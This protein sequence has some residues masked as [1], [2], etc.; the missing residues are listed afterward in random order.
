MKCVACGAELSLHGR[1]NNPKYPSCRNKECRR[2]ASV[3]RERDKVKKSIITMTEERKSGIERM[4]DEIAI[5]EEFLKAAHEL[6]GSRNI[7]K[8]YGITAYDVA[9]Y[10][11]EL[12]GGMTKKEIRALR[13]QVVADIIKEFERKRPEVK[14]YKIIDMEAFEKGG[15]GTYDGLKFDRIEYAKWIDLPFN[16]LEM[17]AI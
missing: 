17:E 16:G 9:K 7:A 10:R 1:G 4:K 14:V 11:E 5:K 15:P 2:I 6:G 8:K 12:F 3:M 13:K